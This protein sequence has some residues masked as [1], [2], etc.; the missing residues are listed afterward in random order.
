MCLQIDDVKDRPIPYITF[1][2]S[3][4]I[5]LVLMK[6]SR[7]KLSYFRAHLTISMQIIEDIIILQLE[8]TANSHVRNRFDNTFPKKFFDSWFISLHNKT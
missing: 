5:F 7:R 2:D 3:L 1:C 4:K 6:N 8:D